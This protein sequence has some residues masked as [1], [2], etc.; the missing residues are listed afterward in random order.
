MDPTEEAWNAADAAVRALTELGDPEMAD[1]Y[2]AAAQVKAL[3]AVAAALDRLASVVDAL[4][5]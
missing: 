3:A 1:R 2:I 4:H 5:P